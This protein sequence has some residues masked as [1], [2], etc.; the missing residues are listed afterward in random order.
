MFESHAADATEALAA[1]VPHLSDDRAANEPMLAALHTAGRSGVGAHRA[2]WLT[3]ADGLAACC[4][5]PQTPARTGPAKVW[6]RTRPAAERLAALVVDEVGPVPLAAI[7]GPS[8]HAQA[9]ADHVATVAARSVVVDMVQRFQVLDGPRSLTPSAATTGPGPNGTLRA[10]TEADA[11]TVIDWAIAFQADA[12][13]PPPPG[14]MVDTGGLTVTI[15]RKLADGEIHLW[16]DGP[17]AQ[18]AAMVAVA[19]RV[20]GLA[21]IH[22]VYTPPARR[23][24]GLAGAATTAACRNAFE[25]GA[26]ACTLFSDLANPTSTGLYR[27][28]GFRPVADHV[29]LRLEPGR[30]R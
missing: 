22:L 20:P 24:Q 29:S 28:L 17:A 8:D 5:A 10:A 27:R 3:D 1:L 6:A 13:G 7:D 30:Q 2:W 12:F 18:P 9:F 26:D 21:R 19:Q 14:A 11:D 15:E 23:G 4:L 25:H 16:L